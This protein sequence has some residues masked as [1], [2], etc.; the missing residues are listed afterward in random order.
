MR[1]ALK[2]TLKSGTDK[3]KSGVDAVRGKER[4]STTIRP[5]TELTAEEADERYRRKMERAQK[6]REDE[7][8]RHQKEKEK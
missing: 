2:R 5:S 3:L 1:S 4:Q 8:K 7:K 6:M